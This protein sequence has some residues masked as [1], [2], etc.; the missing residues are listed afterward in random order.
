MS[1]VSATVSSV[2][3]LL[4]IQFWGHIR[5]EHDLGEKAKRMQKPAL[6]GDLSTVR[7]RHL[8]LKILIRFMH[9]DN[10]KH[11]FSCYFGG[12]TIVIVHHHRRPVLIV[13]TTCASIRSLV[14]GSMSDVHEDH[15]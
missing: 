13:R 2:K 4:G 3:R 11:A 1:M 8:Y 6:F 12:A 14:L 5:P 10:M 15:E 9:E 7:S